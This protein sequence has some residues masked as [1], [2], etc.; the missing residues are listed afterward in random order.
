MNLTSITD[1]NLTAATST[2]INANALYA[3]SSNDIRLTANSE[4]YI[5]APRVI[6]SSL[7]IY[8]TI[9]TN[10]LVIYGQSTLTVQGSAFF[11]SLLSS[12]T[13]LTGALGIFDS[14]T[15]E[16]GYIDYNN[17]SFDLNGASILDQSILT[18]TIEGLGT[19][20]YISSGGG[21]PVGPTVSSLQVQTSSIQTGF[22][23]FNYISIPGGTTN[24][25][26]SSSYLYAGGNVLT[27]ATARQVVT[28]TIS[29]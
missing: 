24:L 29:F 27:G 25:F 22:V 23:V 10:S 11:Q 12:K 26:V 4:V 17:G 20:G 18:S 19:L 8:D 7:L 28:Q 21:G 15:G 6:T 3:S 1:Q 13:V 16:P 2:I 9:S 5:D 14:T